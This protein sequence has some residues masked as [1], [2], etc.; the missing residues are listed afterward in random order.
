LHRKR[1]VGERRRGVRVKEWKRRR[2][3]EASDRRS[4]PFA[5]RREGW[6]TLKFMVLAGSDRRNPRPRYK[7][8]TWGTRHRKRGEGK[9]EVEE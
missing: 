4:P 9:E 3:A 8:G 2:A 6:G 7:S 1:G 5:E